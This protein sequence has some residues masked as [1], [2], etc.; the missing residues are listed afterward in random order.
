MIRLHNCFFSESSKTHLPDEILVC[1]MG[2]R[3]NPSTIFD[4]GAYPTC[5]CVGNKTCFAG[6]N[7]W[8]MRNQKVISFFI[9]NNDTELTRLLFPFFDNLPLVLS[10][11]R[12]YFEDPEIIQYAG[13]RPMN[14]LTV[15]SSIGDQQMDN[16]QYEVRHHLWC[17]WVCNDG[18][19]DIIE[20]QVCSRKN[21]FFIMK[22]GIGQHVY[23]SWILICIS[24][25]DHLP[26]GIKNSRQGK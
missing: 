4:P 2:S 13:F 12:L 18:K 22:S 14:R 15:T 25:S 1:D 9:V 19:K 24:R 21:F 3:V 8:G 7:N 20:K 5:N 26:Q 23:K 10:V 17:T 6:G 16:G 11:P